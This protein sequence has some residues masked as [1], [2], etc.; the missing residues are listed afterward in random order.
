MSLPEN[1][2]EIGTDGPTTIVAAVDGSVTSLRACA[3]AAG[4]ARR[5]HAQLLAV[6]VASVSALAGSSAAGAVAVRESTEETAK[7]L[8]ELL[9]RAAR[10][11]GVA[12]RFCTRTGDPYTEITRLADEV[13]ADALVVGAS[14]HLGHRLVGSLA[15]RLV[16]AGRWPVTVV[17]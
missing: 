7:E 5:E 1:P 2:F 6:Y 11:R 9:D 17:P 4:L 3:Y 15:V 12:M 13:R 16:R 10:E 8:K 14:E